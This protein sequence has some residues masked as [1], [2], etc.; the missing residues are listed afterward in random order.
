M[1]ADLLLPVQAVA[2]H[3]VEAIAV[4]AAVVLHPVDHT[5]ADQVEEVVVLPE[6]EADVAAEEAADKPKPR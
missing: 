2:L 3:R 4:A 1:I 6:E 5:P